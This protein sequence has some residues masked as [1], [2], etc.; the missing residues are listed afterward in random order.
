M[1]A[2]TVGVNWGEFDIDNVKTNGIGLAVNYDMGSG[3]VFQLGYGDGEGV[4]TMSMGL[5]LSF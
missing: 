3:A 2:L 5:A 4:D 1:D